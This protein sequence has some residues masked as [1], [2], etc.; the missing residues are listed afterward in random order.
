M[1]RSISS[2]LAATLMFAAFLFSLVSLGVSLVSAHLDQPWNSATS[3]PTIVAYQGRVTSGGSPVN[4]IGFFKF[5]LVNAAGS[6]TFWSND[7]TS[8][9]GS[10]PS[11]SVP[12]SVTGGLFTVM[13]GDTSLGGMSSPLNASVFTSAD[14]RLRVWLSTN[15]LTFQQLSPDQAIASVPFALNAESLGGFSA[16]AFS[17]KTDIT[18]TVAAAGFLT[19]TLADATYAQATHTHSGADITSGTIADARLSANVVLSGS[20]ISRLNNDANYLNQASADARYVQP[21]QV[22]PIVGAAGFI[23]KTLADSR[24]APTNHQHAA[25]DITSGTL[26]DARLS[27]NVVLSGTA[28][29]RLNNDVGYV[30][31]SGVASAGYLT[32]TLADSLYAPSVHQ[33][34]A[35]DIVSGTLADARLSSD[36]LLTGANIS[37]L[38][39]DAGYLTSTAAGAAGFITKTLADSLYAPVVHQHSAADITSGTLADGRLS[40]NV[41][42][43][44]QNV[45]RLTNDAGYLTYS[46]ASSAGFITQ[47]VAD[48]RYARLNPT[49]QQIALRKWYVAGTA[50][51]SFAVGTSPFNLAFDGANIWV[52]NEGSGTISELRANDGGQVRTVPVG[53]NPKGIAY[54][55]ANIWV[56]NGGTNNVSIIRASDGAS[57]MTVTVGISP[58]GAAF[59]GANMWITNYN[60]NTVSVIRVADGV[61]V[62]T[63]PTGMGPRSLAFDGTNMWITNDLSNTVTEVRA[64]DGFHVGTFTVGTAPRDIVFDGANIWVANDACCPASVSVLRA[65]DG[66]LVKTISIGGN[67]YGMGFDGQNVWVG[68]VG[69]GA[70]VYR[71]SDFALVKNVPVSGGGFGFAFDGA[72]MWVAS[73][74]DNSVAK[75]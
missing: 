71:A 44:G 7:G 38:T 10:Q 63:Y 2:R 65:S 50:P 73:L 21:A 37:R 41:V 11:A 40:T 43:A 55:G 51:I 48:S 52:T 69:L 25:S 14:R 9:A 26:D 12:I 61:I 3:A 56:A 15:A 66:F 60:D 70:L 33:H 36:V 45:S 32:K 57:V 59:D 18:P 20:N 5:A 13:L 34:S 39:N 67:P 47:T 72:N 27:A 17:L 24:Y 62:G 64:S 22:T 35:T 53:T 54:D 58:Y 28:I 74:S 6:A 8:S 16:N 23:T 1:N 31:L 46:T 30:G 4:G 19:K 75:R 29:S 68:N 49:P 42:M